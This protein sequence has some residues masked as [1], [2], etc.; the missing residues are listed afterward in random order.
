MLVGNPTVLS[1]MRLNLG[2]LGIVL[3]LLVWLSIGC[4]ST[5][6]LPTR[7]AIPEVTTIVTTPVPSSTPVSCTPLLEGMTLQVDPVSSVEVQVELEGLQSEEQLIFLFTTEVSGRGGAE[8]EFRPLEM[9]DASGHYSYSQRL[10]P[11]P[12]SITNHWEIKVIHAR[13]V[14]CTEVTLP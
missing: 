11:I 12:G 14:A 2:K 6:V 4:Q 9:V 13:G 10:R 1:V 7:E 3:A 5:S 8:I